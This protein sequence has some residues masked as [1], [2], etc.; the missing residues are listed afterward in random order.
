M[1][2]FAL[3]RPLVS[4]WMEVV[5]RMTEEGGGKSGAHNHRGGGCTSGGGKVV[6]TLP[7]R[8]GSSSQEVESAF[9]G[10][11]RTHLFVNLINQ[12]SEDGNKYF[13]IVELALDVLFARIC[14]AAW[15]R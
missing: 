11:R 12:I 5:S 9:I 8:A 15:R 14:S 2:T 6:C 4:G 10:G 3:R 1:P 7:R 13:L